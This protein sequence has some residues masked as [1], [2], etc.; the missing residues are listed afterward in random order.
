MEPLDVLTIDL[1]RVF[2]F[3]ADRR[4]LLLTVGGHGV[5]CF[6]TGSYPWHRGQW[7]TLREPGSWEANLGRVR[8]IV[9]RVRPGHTIADCAFGAP[10]APLSP[11]PSKPRVRVKAPSIRSAPEAT[12]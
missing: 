4:N 1:G 2:Q 8:L 11:A 9:S 3:A 12:A 7:W 6:L 10:T 5:D